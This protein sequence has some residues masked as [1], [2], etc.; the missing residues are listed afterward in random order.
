MTIQQLIYAVTIA[1]CHSMNKAAQVLFLSQSSLSVS[2]QNLEEELGISLF[3]RTNRG[4]STTP[5]GE[6]FL[7]YARQL[8][9]QYHL[10][11][12]K[13]IQKK[14]SRKSF[15]VSSQHYSFA[16]KAFIEMAKHFRL[17]QYAFGMY[18]CKTA[19]ILENVRKYKSELGILYLDD[20]NR[21]SLLRLFE[22]N[23]LV[24]TELFSCG[25][26]V[27]LAGRH[28][29]AGREILTMEELEPWPF[30]S[31]DQ[32]ENETFYLS[33]EVYSTWQY[34][35]LIRASDRATF[36]NMMVGLNGYTLCSGILCEDLNGTDYCTV[37]L[38]TDKK[39]H[40]GYIRRRDSEISELGRLYIDELLKCDAHILGA[41]QR[42]V[43]K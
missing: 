27:F 36:L 17:D 14:K 38:D 33:E 41:E 43:Q 31:F 13:F 10:T 42:T 11:E 35:Q 25:V 18:E 5:E 24:F 15:S 20:F 16:V 9:H 28:P 39:M 19:E 34:R 26:Y 37:P 32:G 2:V 30:L 4:V 23:D 8:V 6:E 7:I 40:I 3:R 22:D 29:L 12:E 1:G 21:E